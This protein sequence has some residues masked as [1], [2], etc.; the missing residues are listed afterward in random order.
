MKRE[1]TLPFL[2][3]YFPLLLV[4][5]IVGWGGWYV[6]SHP[7]ELKTIT[8][9]SPGWLLLLFGLAAAKIACM[10]SFTKVIVG[11][12][13]IELDI[14]E[15]FGLSAMSTMGNY[16][17]PFRGGAAV[18]AVY[19][20]SRHGL[21]YSLFLSTLS[22]LYVITFA[23]SAALGLLAVL[24]LYLWFGFI[25]GALVLFFVFCLSLP[26]LLFSLARV[27][28]R[29]PRRWE[30]QKISGIPPGLNGPAPLAYLISRCME[31]VNRIIEGWQV[32][33]AHGGTLAHLVGLSLLNASVTLLMIHFSF[34]AFAVRLPL[35]ESLVLSSLFMLSALI[36]IT[37]SGLGVAEAMLVMASRGFGVGGSLSVLSAGLNRSMMLL[38]SLLWG[39]LFSYILGRRAVPAMASDTL[40]DITS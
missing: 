9:L 29:L 26:V 22:T 30:P 39:S 7:A 12:L 6:Y 20:K 32:I 37:P 24:L 33:S 35:L 13:G 2:R 4:A 38:S 28:P 34:A 27:M 19:L 14:L 11:S 5:G 16:L 21:P 17:T 1:N 23:T 36:P 25:D 10:G 18:R 15:W 31:V 3:R 40:E 8:G